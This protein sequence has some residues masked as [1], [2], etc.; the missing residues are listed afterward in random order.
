[1]TALSIYNAIT[2][3]DITKGK[4]K[5]KTEGEEFSLDVANLVKNH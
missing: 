3:K 5:I 4:I 2:K 1:M